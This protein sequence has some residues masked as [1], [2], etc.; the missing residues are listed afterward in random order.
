VFAAYF[1]V[2]VR[3]L[4]KKPLPKQMAHFTFHFGRVRDGVGDFR[5]NELAKTLPQ[6]MHGH[7]DV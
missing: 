2:T 5:A 1:G 6:A 7:S 4:Q 3:G